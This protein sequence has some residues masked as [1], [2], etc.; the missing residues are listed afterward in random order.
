MKGD[1]ESES[2]L[3]FFDE[4]K[5]C[6]LVSNQTK[7]SRKGRTHAGYASRKEHDAA[8]YAASP[9]GI[10]GKEKKRLKQMDLKQM[11]TVSRKDYGSEKEY[12]A[13][14][15]QARRGKLAAYNAAKYAAKAPEM[16]AKYAA[17]KDAQDAL[18]RA[19]QAAAGFSAEELGPSY[20]EIKQQIDGQFQ[21]GDGWVKITDVD[22]QVWS[23]EGVRWHRAYI[24][25]DEP[26]RISKESVRPFYKTGEYEPWL[27]Q[28][29][30]VEGVHLKIGK[31]FLQDLLQCRLKMYVSEVVRF[32]SEVQIQ[33]WFVSNL[34]FRV[35]KEAL[36][37]GGHWRIEFSF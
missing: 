32:K 14:R 28:A 1:G 26:D 3:S 4:E 35:R 8:K 36:G 12:Q 19:A 2:R 33:K 30:V 7:F 23:F 34:R 5:C 31:P 10:A 29:K 20:E 18:C 16:A 6:S 21:W 22:G 17:D 15:Y 25:I 27:V 37:S 13:A 24:A 9:A 11:E